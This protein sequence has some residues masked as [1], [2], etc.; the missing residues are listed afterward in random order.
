MNYNPLDYGTFMTC[1]SPISRALITYRDE[2]WVHRPLAACNTTSH[3]KPRATKA[4]G[5]YS[6][7]DGVLSHT[8]VVC[9]K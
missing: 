6:S 7:N 9:N 1:A 3:T 8:K 2:A 4:R 5:Q